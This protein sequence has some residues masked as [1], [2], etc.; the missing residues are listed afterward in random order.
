MFANA[1]LFVFGAVQHTGV[2][3]GPFQEPRI[4]PAAIVEGACAI[5]LV[6]GAIA[7]FGG[8]THGWRNAMIANLFALSGVVLGM[9]ALAAGAGPRTASNDLYH[10]IMLALIGAALVLLFV[11]SRR[12]IV[13]RS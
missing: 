7:I 1:A 13:R 3:L 4:I 5:A 10:G 12:P 8:R 2:T 9:A 6:W 11:R